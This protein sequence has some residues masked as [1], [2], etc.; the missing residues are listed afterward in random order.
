MVH[1]DLCLIT[2]MEVLSVL[3]VFWWGLRSFTIRIMPY[4]NKD[5]L[6]S[7]I[8]I[9]IYF[10]F[11]LIILLQLGHQALNWIKKEIVHTFVLLQILEKTITVL[12]PFSIMLAIGLSYTFA[13]VILRYIPS[14][15]SF[16]GGLYHEEGILNSLEDLWHI[17][18]G[19]DI[20]SVRNSICVLYYTVFFF[21]FFAYV[22]SNPTCIPGIK[23]VQPCD[24]ILMC[25]GI[26]IVRQLFRIL[27]SMFITE[28]SLCFSLFVVFSLSVVSG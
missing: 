14:I 7:F 23:T 9:C 19:D 1:V 11:S 13:L 16:F 8:P 21:F 22:E 17:R 26:H 18:W 28:I 20:V 6:T 10:I 3:R 25:Y 15:S 12:L 2:L 5:S 4:E 24:M 27:A